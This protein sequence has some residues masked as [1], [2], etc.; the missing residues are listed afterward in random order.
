MLVADFEIISTKPFPT[1]LMLSPFMA[2]YLNW[3][4]LRRSVAPWSA[5]RA[6][7]LLQSVIYKLTCVAYKTKIQNRLIAL[8]I[9]CVKGHTDCL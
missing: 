6:E 1:V 8:V 4:I 7:R 5:S 3:F 9:Q 2:T